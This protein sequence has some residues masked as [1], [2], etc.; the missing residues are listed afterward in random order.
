MREFELKTIQS[1]NIFPTE[2]EWLFVVFVTSVPK[3]R[4]KKNK[5]N[6]CI[7]LTLS[8]LDSVQT[9]SFNNTSENRGNVQTNSFA[10]IVFFVQ[11]NSFVR[12]FIFQIFAQTKSFDKTFDNLESS[13]QK[14]SFCKKL[15]RH[16]LRILLQ[17][18][19]F[20]LCRKLFKQVIMSFA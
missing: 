16:A 3:H 9:K 11:T 10:L 19:F 8:M 17:S 1:K 14:K 15:L 18:G 6:S 13:N 4:K 20:F 12:L 2:Q 7:N 5:K